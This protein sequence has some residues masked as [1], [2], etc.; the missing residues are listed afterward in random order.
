VFDRQ[1]LAAMRT[2]VPGNNPGFGVLDQFCFVATHA[3]A[4]RR[5]SS[6]PTSVRRWRSTGCSTPASSTITSPS[7]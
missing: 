7:R 6:T 3:A 4:T 2:T 1:L 5:R